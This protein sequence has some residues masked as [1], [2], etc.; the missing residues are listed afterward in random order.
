MLFS[1]IIVNYNLTQEVKDCLESISLNFDK[2]NY[3][4]ILVDNNSVDK[5]INDVVLSI[6][7]KLQDRFTYIQLNENI[8][9]G[10]AC[11]I[12]SEKSIGDILF[13]LNPDTTINFDI[14]SQVSKKIKDLN[15]EFGIV[16][17]KV[18]KKKFIDFSAGV[19]PNLFLEVFNIFAIGRYLE[20][21]YIRIKCLLT[22]LNQVE[23]DWV[24]GSALFISKELFNEV[25]KFDRDYFLYFEEMDLCRRVKNKSKSVIYFHSIEI[26]H[27]GSASTK[28]NYYFFTKMF[29]K[30]KLLFLMKHTQGNKYSILLLL[31]KVHIYFQIVLWIILKFKNE[32]KSKGKVMAF[33]ETLKYLS[34]PKMISNS[35]VPN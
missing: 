35:A 23:V 30:G 26:K 12:A 8:G 7:N 21:L 6:K 10:G 17:I 28:K 32:E 18:S 33:K 11:N 27:I 1:I 34:N 14:L 16:G 5:S 20:A 22:T 2:F 29:Y 24:M 13:F 3:E 9:F 4:V 19:F 15:K 31:M 25:G